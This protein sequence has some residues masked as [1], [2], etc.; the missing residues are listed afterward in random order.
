MDATSSY[1]DTF[2]AGKGDRA[3]VVKPKDNLHVHASDLSRSAPMSQTQRDYCAKKA[4]RPEPHKPGEM[5][6][7]IHNASFDSTTET[8]H[9][10]KG[11]V[12]D[13]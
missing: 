5:F 8:K 2:K 11:G 3:A 4:E 7:V 13:R 12:G 9:S 6:P 1:G 10:F